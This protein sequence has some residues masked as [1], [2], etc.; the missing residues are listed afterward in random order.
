MRVGHVK[1]RTMAAGLHAGVLKHLPCG[2]EDVAW[3]DYKSRGPLR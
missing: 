1:E 2:R 3:L